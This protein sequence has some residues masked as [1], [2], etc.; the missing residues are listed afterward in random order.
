MSPWITRIRSS[1]RPSQSSSICAYIV[2]WP[3]PYEKV[4]ATMVAS[5]VGSKRISIRSETVAHTS[6]Y[7]PSPRPRRRPRASVACPPRG[8]AVPVGERARGVEDRLE[9]AAVVGLAD[10]GP[11]RRHRDEIAPAQGD[12]IDAELA[13]GLVERALDEID[14]FRPAGA[15]VGGE[16]PRMRQHTAHGR[17]ASPGSRTRPTAS[18]RRSAADARR[19]GRPGSRGCDGSSR[20]S[21]GS[22]P[23]ASNAISASASWSRPLKSARNDSLRSAIHFTGRPIRPA[24]QSTATSSG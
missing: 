9:L 6:M 21:R 2:S 23:S 14:R 16:R 13:R 11:V 24:A 4:P 15:A 8:I 1:G 17:R 22:C 3:W 18:A 10:R 12:R 7:I 20:G 19:T 5:P